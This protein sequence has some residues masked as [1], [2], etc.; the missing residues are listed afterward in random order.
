Q[1]RGCEALADA[2]GCVLNIYRHF[3]CRRILTAPRL[4]PGTLDTRLI[5][6]RNHERVTIR[7]VL[8]PGF[9]FVS[10]LVEIQHRWLTTV[11]ERKSESQSGQRKDCSSHLGLSELG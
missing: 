3:H 6:F 8:Q 4:A 10:Q 1:G 9:D 5:D 11:K 7:F 2:G